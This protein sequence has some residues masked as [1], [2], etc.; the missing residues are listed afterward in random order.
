[1]IMSASQPR[2][3]LCMA[4]CLNR[5]R[6]RISRVM[7]CVPAGSTP[8]FPFLTRGDSRGVFFT[9]CFVRSA[10]HATTLQYS[11]NGSLSCCSLLC[12]G[13]YYVQDFLRAGY[14]NFRI[15]LVDEPAEYVEPL[16]QR[17]CDMVLGTAPAGQL[18]RWLRELPDANGRQHGVGS[19][20]LETHQERTA[21]S[22]RPSARRR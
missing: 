10:L 16:L 7:S 1:M 18:W 22:L 5:V 17:Y 12:A 3:K 14:R 6:S 19:G 21:K 13:A 11:I 2:H 20:S 15:E 8:H 9:P 4:L